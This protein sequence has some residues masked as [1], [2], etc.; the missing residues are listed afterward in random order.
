MDL[1]EFFA[2]G[3]H[4]FYIWWS[5]GV[6]MLLMVGEAVFVA[7]RYKKS[8]QALAQMELEFLCA[9]STKV[10]NGQGIK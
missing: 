4:G 9:N 10:T 1:K 5:Y 8:K 7:R 6:A 3:G 2:M